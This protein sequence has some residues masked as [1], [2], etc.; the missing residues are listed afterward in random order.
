[1]ADPQLTAEIYLYPDKEGTKK[2]RPISEFYRPVGFLQLDHSGLGHECIF[3]IGQPPLLA[4][5]RRRVRFWSTHQ[6]SL[7]ALRTVRKFYIWDGWF[8][9]EAIIIVDGD[10]ISN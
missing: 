8:V 10:E 9:G 1:M 2:K 3:E 4:G 7:A 5:E 6:E